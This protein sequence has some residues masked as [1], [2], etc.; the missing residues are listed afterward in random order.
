MQA[1]QNADDKEQAEYDKQH[2]G[3]YADSGIGARRHRGAV[4]GVLAIADQ[5]ERRQQACP[6]QPHLQTGVVNIEAGLAQFR[7]LAQGKLRLLPNIYGLAQRRQGRLS[8]RLGAI[9]VSSS[10]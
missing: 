3:L 4:A 10:R 6:G 7:T 9:R 1:R 2:G 5:A 8:Q